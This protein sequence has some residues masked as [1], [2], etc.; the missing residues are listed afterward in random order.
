MPVWLFV[1]LQLRRRLWLTSSLYCA[2]GVVAALL[3]AHFGRYVPAEFPLQL[4]SDAVDDILSILASSM[5]AVTTFSLATLVTA[6]TSVVGNVAPHAAKLMVADGGVRNALATFIGAFLFAIVGIIAVHTGYYGAQGRVIL[7]FFTLA[8]LGLVLVAMIRWVGQLSSLGQ[9]GDVIDLVTAATAKALRSHA[10]VRGRADDAPPEGALSVHAAGIG[11]VQNIDLAALEQLADAY[12]A[13]IVVTARA[14]SF[15]H[16]GEPL[17]WV[18]GGSLSTACVGELRSKVTIGVE[19]TLDQDPRYG[20]QVLGEIAARALSPGV[21]DIGIAR[22]VITR[23]SILLQT[24]IA[25]GP[26]APVA[27]RGRV[28]MRP[29]MAAEL[30]TEVFDPVARYGRSDARLQGELQDRLAAL[31]GLG[32]EE[33]TAAAARLSQRALQRALAALG[34]EDDRAH[35]MR[36]AARLNAVVAR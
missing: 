30:L 1:L 34:D 21:N 26:A 2:L 5:L 29:T 35:L 9:P 32:D 24:W 27:A 12:G 20:L 18:L 19:R 10:T 7:F 3:A 11:F 33:M 28:R 4:G 13:E 14:G 31:A 36:A 25:D 8:V 23:A 15:V 17:M 22:D 6:Y 16:S